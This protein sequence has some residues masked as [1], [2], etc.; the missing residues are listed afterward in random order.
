M[1]LAGV[2]DWAA[3]EVVARDGAVEY[4]EGVAVVRIEE[5]ER[6]VD[7]TMIDGRWLHEGG[8]VS[9]SGGWVGVCW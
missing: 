5:N 7:K 6:V 9:E 3:R 1:L 4:A 8:V 2:E